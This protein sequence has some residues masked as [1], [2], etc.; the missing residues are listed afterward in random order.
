[1]ERGQDPQGG[2]LNTDSL[3]GSIRRV[4]RSALDG[5]MNE[6]QAVSALLALVAEK[7]R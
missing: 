5:D 1:M 2:Q 7:D 3:E 4:V 6:D